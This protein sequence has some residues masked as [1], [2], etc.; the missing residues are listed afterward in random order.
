MADLFPGIRQMVRRVR[1]WMHRQLR[2]HRCQMCS[3]RLWPWRRYEHP[4]F[5]SQACWDETPF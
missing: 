3:R 5:C 4:G 2:M 1:H